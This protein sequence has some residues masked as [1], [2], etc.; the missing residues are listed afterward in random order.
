[1]F[2]VRV[3]TRI[4]LNCPHCRFS[5]R[6]DTGFLEDAIHDNKKISCVACGCHF[7]IVVRKVEAN[8]H[9]EFISDVYDIMKDGDGMSQ[10][11][12][13]VDIVDM[14]EKYLSAQQNMHPTPSKRGDS[15]RSRVRKNKQVL[16]AISG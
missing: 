14:L 15:A 5:S 10:K 13:V 2:P 4:L 8:N 12:L 6:Y 9:L 11:N 1:M 3:E 7:E 16:P